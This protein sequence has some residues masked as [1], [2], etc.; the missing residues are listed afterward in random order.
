VYGRSSND[1]VEESTRRVIKDCLLEIS[2]LL[3]IDRLQ[4]NHVGNNG[5]V[6]RDFFSPDLTKKI[7]SVL[8]IPHEYL[9]KVGLLVRSLNSGYKL[10]TKNYRTMATVVHNGWYELL[11]NVYMPVGLHIIVKHVADYQDLLDIPVGWTSEDAL[12][13]LHRVIKRV[14]RGHIIT[15]SLT[16]AHK[17][18]MKYLL[19]ISCPSIAAY[20]NNF[21]KIEKS[22]ID[23]DLA[24]LIII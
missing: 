6:A 17:S 20:H 7:A 2:P 18:L 16:M 8:N 14:F 10:N 5:N 22:E 1:K 4:H 23:S 11:P 24:K 19:L 9:Y 13:H 12:E 21:F 15:S 3:V